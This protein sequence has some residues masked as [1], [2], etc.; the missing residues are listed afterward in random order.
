MLK[1][2][3]HKSFLANLSSRPGV[4]RM[5]DEEGTVIYVGKAKNLKKRVTSYFRASGL[6]TKTM[7]M[8]AKIQ[9]IEVTITNSETEALLL[10]QSLIKSARPVYNIQL[11]DDKSYPYIL[12]TEKD[13]YPRL[14]FYRGSRKRQGKFFGPYPSAH[15]TR[16]TL[17]VLQKVFKIRQC[18]DSYFKNRSRPCLQHQ[19][20]RC[21]APCVGLIDPEEYSRDV[22]YSTLFLQGKSN[23]LH[24]ELTRSMESAAAKEDFERAAS[25]RDQIVDLRRIQE[26]QFVANQGGDADIIAA[27]IEGSYASVH[28]IYVRAGRIIGSKSFFPKFRL[29]DSR[30]QLLEAFLSQLYL[31]DE[32]TAN[33][34]AEI[35]TQAISEDGGDI[36]EALNYVAQRK[37]KLATRVRG[38]RAKWLEL[39]DTNARESLQAN[40]SNKQNIT[41]R[42]RSLQES[43]KLESIPERIECFDIS[44]TSGEET[45]G[46]C[47]VFDSNGAVKSDYRRFNIKDISPGDDYAAMEQVLTRRF[48]RLAR[49]EAKIPDIL[50]I[51]GGKGQLTQARKVL[52]E[53]QLPEIQLLGIAKG[54]SRRAGQETLFLELNGRYKE[55]ALPTQSPALHL[56]QQVRDEAHRFAIT[57]HRQRRAKARKQ[58]ALEQIPGLGPKR[59]RDLLRHFGGQQEIVRASESDL[60][61][62]TGISKKLAENIYE[63]LHNN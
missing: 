20:D 28:V 53:F 9:D 19:I 44:H 48:T 34:P 57:G 22:H 7:A 10:E 41:K 32:Q 24:K 49:G 35:I 43:L 39:A 45:V 31:G 17:Q 56:L 61:K 3:D 16:D 1:V 8:V 15:A 5:V 6:T 21:T 11:R 59:R 47:V 63:Y 14:S 36:E 33:I 23:V 46:S 42:F 50:L 58:S 26:Q 4:Y 27:A 38:H 62:V 29:M 37:V 51:D 2:F 30:E 52:E 60:A 55:I 18:Q 40:I 12:L 54:I 13:E 25:I